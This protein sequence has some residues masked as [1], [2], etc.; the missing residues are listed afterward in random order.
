MFIVSPQVRKLQA[1]LTMKFIKLVIYFISLTA[2]L[3][4]TAL[5]ENVDKV[6]DKLFKKVEAELTNLKQQNNLTVQST[7]QLVEKELLVNIDEK[8]F[9]YKV[10]GKHLVKLT[11]EQKTEF[12]SVLKDTLVANYAS[13]L[14]NYNNEKIVLASSIMT[15]SNKGASITMKLVGENKTTQLTTKWRFSDVED[16]WLMYDFVIEGISLLQSKQKELA[17]VLATSGPEA[18]LELLKSKIKK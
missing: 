18:T 2:L 17:K 16:K 10:L 5:A 6:A 8:F 7:K 3:T 11:P 4:G 1:L 12:V 9:A 14:V 13:S 15:N